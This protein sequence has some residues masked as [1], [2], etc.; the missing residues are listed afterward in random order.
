MLSDEAE[1]G[2]GSYIVYNNM[3][4]KGVEDYEDTSQND[5][6][7]FSLKWDAPTEAGQKARGTFRRQND[8]DEDGKAPVSKL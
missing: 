5:F 1:N 7:K 3:V 6:I 2:E 4:N 8:E